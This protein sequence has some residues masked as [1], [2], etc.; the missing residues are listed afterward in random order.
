VELA[1]AS[2]DKSS[3][4]VGL[5][6]DGKAQEVDVRIPKKLKTADL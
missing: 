5:I 3:I 1:R 4:K 6:R 2:K